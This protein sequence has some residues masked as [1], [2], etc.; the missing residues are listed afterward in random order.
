MR[1]VIVGPGV[2]GETLGGAFRRAYPHEELIYLGPVSPRRSELARRY[3]AGEATHPSEIGA[4]DW[5]ILALK[6]QKA[7]QVLPML[8]PLLH[9]ETLVLSVMAGITLGHL[10]QALA[11]SK[12][13]RCMPNTPGRIGAGIT[14][15]TAQNLEDEEKATVERF[16]EGMG[17]SLYVEEEIYVDMATALSG[18]GPA[19]VYLFMEALMDAGVHMGLPRHLAEKLVVETLRGAVAYYD[20]NPRGA[21]ALRHEVTSPGGTTAEAIYHLEKAGFRPALSKAVWA[22]YQRALALRPKVEE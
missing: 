21:A 16:L 8:R 19:Y 9:K 18:T 17:T 20:K 15:W 14:A 12:L 10:R 6:P 3:A 22:A 5:L 13:V 7:A 11:H 2:M 4:V 1:A